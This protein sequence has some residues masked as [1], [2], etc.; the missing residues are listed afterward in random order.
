MQPESI[1]GILI[2]PQ[3]RSVAQVTIPHDNRRLNLR[4]REAL[5]A[6]LVDAIVFDQAHDLWIDDEGLYQDP[7][8]HG[9]FVFGKKLIAG[10]GLIL[11]HDGA[12]GSVGAH[13]DVFEVR[14]RIE[15]KTAAELTPE[16]RE[17]NITVLSL[18]EDGNVKGLRM[19]F[20]LPP[21]GEEG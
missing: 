9:Y 13:L 16:Q 7:N 12:G 21:P 20:F 15:F 14:R 1:K 5:G 2:D 3:R 17:P 11:G 8:P 19:P 10:R 4:I 6:E 18:D